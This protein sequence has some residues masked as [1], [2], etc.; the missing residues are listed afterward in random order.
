MR[1]TPNECPAIMVF[2]TVVRRRLKSPDQ[3]YRHHASCSKRFVCLVS[4]RLC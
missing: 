4:G 2:E 3:S 1:V